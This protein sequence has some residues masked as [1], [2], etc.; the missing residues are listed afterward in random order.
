MRVINVAMDTALQNSSILR[1]KVVTADF[2]NL[3][4][5]YG[6]SI[7]RIGNPIRRQLASHGFIVS[8][9]SLATLLAGHSEG[10]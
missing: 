6:I 9:Q 10:D 7:G 2:F 8:A 3:L 1:Y 4:F 5:G